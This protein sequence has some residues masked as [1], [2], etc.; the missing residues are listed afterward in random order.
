[1]NVCVCELIDGGDVVCIMVVVVGVQEMISYIFG[2][3]GD[4]IW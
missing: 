3:C 4:R 2:G 1:M